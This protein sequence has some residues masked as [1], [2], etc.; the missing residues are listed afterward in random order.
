[1]K[2]LLFMLVALIIVSRLDA[3]ILAWNLLGAA[4]NEATSNSTLTNPNLE[5]STLS[6]GAGIAV[7]PAGGSYASTFPVNID[8]AA[9]RVAGAYY[10]F[11]ITPKGSSLVSLTTLDVILRIQTNAPPTYIWRYSKDNGITFNDIGA[12]YTWTTGFSQNNG[13][14]QPTIDLSGINDL[15]Q[16][17][18][19]VIFRLYAWG[20]TSATSNNGFRIGKSLDETQNALAIGGTI[21]PLIAWNLLGAAGDEA[22]SSSTLTNPNLEVSVL[23]RGP[24][25]Q[26]QTAGGSYASTFPVNADSV[27]AR[28]AGA[29]YEFTVTPK[30]NAMVSLT[31]L[32]VILRIQTSAPPTYIWRYSKDGGVAFTDIGTPYTW[33]TGFTQNNGIQQPAIDLSGI[34]DLQNVSTPVIFRLYAWGGTSATSNNGFRIGKSLTATQDALAIS[35]IIEQENTLPVVLTSFTGK[36]DAGKIK[37]HWITASEQNNAYFEILRS[38]DGRP[39]TVI[40]TVT[41]NGTTNTTSNYNYMD[42]KPLPEDN[43]YQLRQVDFNGNIT[44]SPVIHINAGFKQTELQVYTPSGDEA[45]HVAVYTEHAGRATVSI[46]NMLGQVV[47]KQDCKLEKGYNDLRLAVA[48]PKNIYIARL[49]SSTENVSTKFLR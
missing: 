46:T 16:F 49:S 39:F 25:I 9:A 11:T 23:S 32:N 2:K 12:P 20:G 14:Q 5:I 41:G 1:M 18:T 15:Q 37:L 10:E 45:I 4:G 28:V 21:T 31:T 13:I 7:Q 42:S 8:S 27:A 22:T 6:R 47:I 33:T 30:G 24:G 26:A 48:L 38:T 29:Y 3:Q 19:P 34:S 36:L 44:G 43:Y 40:G 17:N 35:G